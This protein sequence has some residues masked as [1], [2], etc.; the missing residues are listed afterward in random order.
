MEPV[1]QAFVSAY[2]VEKDIATPVRVF[3]PDCHLKIVKQKQQLCVCV[4]FWTITMGVYTFTFSNTKQN[5]ISIV[6]SYDGHKTDC[7]SE[8]F[9]RWVNLAEPL[10]VHHAI[11]R[12][13][14]QF[15][16][17]KEL[18]NAMDKQSMVF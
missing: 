2:T 18:A 4:I 3:T 6:K 5:T 9:P 8:T 14:L 10:G 16:C 13:A 17:M 15:T 12:L 11:K 1:A 7:I